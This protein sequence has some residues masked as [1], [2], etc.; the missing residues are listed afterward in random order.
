MI[1]FDLN[2][3][4]YTL[5]PNEHDED[6][7]KNRLHA[8]PEVRFVSFTGVDMGGHN[9]DEKIPV[10]AFL[11]DMGKLLSEGVQTDGSSVAL[12]TIADLSNAR[13][14]IMPDS[15]VNWYVEYNFDNIDYE[16]GLPTGTLRIPSFLRHNGDTMVG[17][18][19]FLK[20]SVDRFKAAF[21][22]ILKDNPY[23]FEH[24]G[25]ISSADEIDE[26]LLTNA[27]ELEFWVK[28][29]DDRADRN[30]LSIAQEL[31][32][33]YWK[34]VTGP[35]GTAMEQTLEILDH[36]G[37]GVE[38]GHKE[39]GGV[40]AKM[41][42]TGIFDHIMEQLEIDWKYSNPM[43]AADNESQV[44]NIVRD[45]FRMNSLEVTFRAK[46][47]HGVAGSGEHTHFGLAARLK[48]GKIV[49]LFEPSNREDEFMSPVGFGALM[50][51]LRNYEMLNPI[52]SSTHDAFQRLKP[53][54]EAP[55]CIVTSLGVD[56]KTP[57]RNR[58]ILIGL[59]RDLKNPLSTRFELR[60]PNPHT[61]TYL[62]IGAAY[63]TMLDGIRAALEA[64]KTPK[65]L[66][67]SI[68]KKYG[69]RDFYLEK[70]RE[71]RSERNIYTDYTREEREKLFGEPPANVW[72]CFK[73]WGDQKDPIRNAGL[74]TGGD[75][76][77]AM[78]L[79]SYRAQMILKWSMEYHDR[80]I[81][82]TMDYLR[83]CVKLHE[84]DSNEYDVANWN[85]IT[86]LKELIG[87]E[88][89]GHVSL[90]MQARNAIDEVNYEELSKLEIEIEE[91]LEELRFVYNKYRRNIF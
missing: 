34:R 63:M 41:G 84:D 38:M 4:L 85:E 58:T 83:G 6:T 68:S 89:N 69:K 88:S 47:M 56:H 79:R 70:N 11:D 60:S 90:L 67:A 8:H 31:K 61:N 25:G 78:I 12:P 35:V 74:L 62:I 10:N 14:D 44:K 37:F 86:R 73:A 64:S 18:R 48:S 26:L 71:Y 42:N 55:V 51:I 7:I 65:E 28:T 5:R 33:Q 20:D 87:H 27:T 16:T 50:G 59:V 49:N 46:P 53:G 77:I 2:R 57:S 19:T 76:R 54:Y 43:Q 15:D 36:Y 72:Q 40:K 22:Q 82:N 9:T 23:V 75:E 21:E 80:Y 52:V 81:E 1:K 30:Q 3:M 17:S 24:I 13:V 66:E 32:E 39:V 29:P 45:V 91:K